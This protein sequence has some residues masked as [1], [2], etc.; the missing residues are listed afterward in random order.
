MEENSIAQ[1]FTPF[2]R[3]FRDALKPTADVGGKPRRDE[4]ANRANLAVRHDFT[5][6]TD[7]LVRSSSQDSSEGA[8]CGLPSGL[9]DLR[10]PLKPL[11]PA[12][13]PGMLNRK[14]EFHADHR[15]GSDRD[16]RHAS[17]GG[18]GGAA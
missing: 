4:G 6:G 3:V 16:H 9:A 15:G 1:H 8:A 7:F 11:P 14:G 18:A 12:P 10:A 5:V 2:H 17:G 13:P